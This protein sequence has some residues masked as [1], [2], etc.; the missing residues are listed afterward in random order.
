M[1]IDPERRPN[2]GGP[3]LWAKCFDRLDI[4]PGERVLHVGAGT[5]ITA[6]FSPNSSVGMAPSM[7]SR[8]TELW[9]SALEAG[10]R[11]TPKVEVIAGDARSCEVGEVD[12][13][14]A[15]ADMTHPAP[16]WLDRLADR[17]RLLIPLTAGWRGFLLKATRSGAAFAA[18]AL[19]WLSIFPCAGGQDAAAERLRRALVRG[20]P[21]LRAFIAVRRR[22][23]SRTAG[24]PD[25]TS[26]SRETFRCYWT[27]P[28]AAK[29]RA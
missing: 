17:G 10:L 24:T 29:S 2:N 7:P 12:L 28:T 20:Y 26:G 1:S 25:P 5:G 22:P 4:R 14:I 6:P 9:P 27:P 3:S 21:K 16:L 11:C 18:E 13:V 8:S 23:T 15:S 19:G